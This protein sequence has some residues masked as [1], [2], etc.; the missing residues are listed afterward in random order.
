MFRPSH[1]S[2]SIL[3]LG[4]QP[5]ENF[6]SCATRSGPSLEMSPA[7]L[8]SQS[9][10]SALVAPST[11][12]SSR[13]SASA[14][15]VARPLPMAQ[16]AT[17][18]SASTGQRP[19]SR[20]G[21]AN[22]MRRPATLRSTGPRSPARRAAAPNAPSSPVSANPGGGR[23]GSP[24]G[25]SLCHSSIGSASSSRRPSPAHPFV[26]LDQSSRPAGH[27]DARRA[28]AS[29]RAGCRHRPAISAARGSAS[30]AGSSA[31]DPLSPRPNFSP[32]TIGRLVRSI[33]VGRWSAGRGGTGALGDRSRNAM[34]CD[35][36][37][38]KQRQRR[39]PQLAH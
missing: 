1:D 23:S 4:T 35:R 7:R 28:A 25:R 36:R 27:W 32:K 22:R 8:V 5:V 9:R 30:R 20:P 2:C 21:E 17:S 31:A 15:I 18:P 3:V 14:M 16:R 26:E 37:D 13:K 38:D 29:R 12:R 33:S 11:P 34:R 39:H 19:T 10:L 6:V 24:S